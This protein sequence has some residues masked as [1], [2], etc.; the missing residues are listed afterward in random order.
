MDPVVARKTWRTLEPVH[1]MIYFAPEGREVYA[2]AGLCGNRMGY[3]ASRAAPMGPVPAEVVIATFFNFEPSLVRASIPEAWRLATP[4]KVLAARLDAVDRALRRV[5]GDDVI[6]SADVATAA[7]LARTAALT[8]SEHPEG[9]P[10]FAGHTALAWPDEPHLVLWHAQALLREFRGDGHVATL[11]AEGLSGI[12]ALVIHEATGEIPDGVL[13][14]SRAWTAD[15]WAAA[16]ERL[17]ERGLVEAGDELR[18]TDAGQINRLSVE[19][20]T[21]ALALS[22]YVP[23]GDDGCQRLREIGRPLS[24]AVVDAGLLTPDPSDW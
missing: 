15:D 2:A 8:A 3:F 10:L 7:D 11:V 21:D 4:E 6:R 16:V 24:R 14:T 5:W 19:E 1:A 12:E 9:R 18:L 20:R 23:L 13:R 17:T 22:A